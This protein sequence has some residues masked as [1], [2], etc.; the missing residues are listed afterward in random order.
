VTGTLQIPPGAATSATTQISE[1]RFIFESYN[2]DD[3][4]NVFSKDLGTGLEEGDEVGCIIHEGIVPLEGKSLKCVLHIGTNSTDKPMI[5][6]L[7]Y[8]YIDP[9]T[10]IK[11]SFGG[12]Q[13][14]N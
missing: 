8:D 1:F 13:S 5:T 9:G 14:L 7:N 10:T 4:T 6:V 12:I 11:I 3:A 2:A